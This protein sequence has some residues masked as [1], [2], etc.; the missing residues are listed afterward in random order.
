MK[1]YYFVPAIILVVL[2]GL[3]GGASAFSI[4]VLNDGSQ[5][6]AMT[7]INY[8]ASQNA[9]TTVTTL[10]PNSTFNAI[11]VAT[12][13]SDYDVLIMPWYVNTSADLDWTTRI[14]PY[15]EAGGSVLWE[16]PYNTGDLSGSGIT[17]GGT[18]HYNSSISLVSPFDANGAQGYYHIHYGISSV[19]SAWDIWST[20]TGGGIHGIYGEFGT[21]GGRMVM[22]ISDNLYH[23]NFN[24][25]I[26]DDHYQLF[27]NEINWL[28]TGSVYTPPSAVPEP[29]TMFLLGTGLISLAG[30]RRKFRK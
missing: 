2:F 12:L 24:N 21:N 26:D 28:A 1:K 10:S 5:Y 11:P 30:V 27:V 18:G 3:A 15:L 9:G 25:P 16:D 19:T 20:D 8:Y 7:N 22:G 23:P 13:A 29:A 4:G 14:L 17:F 6:N